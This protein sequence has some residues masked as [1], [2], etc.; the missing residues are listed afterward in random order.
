MQY[1]VSIYVRSWCIYIDVYSEYACLSPVKPLCVVPTVYFD[2]E[3]YIVNEAEGIEQAPKLILSKPVP[4]A[5]TVYITAQ[6]G[7]AKGM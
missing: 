5:I 3:T 1:I 2:Q 7:S 4:Q 6:D